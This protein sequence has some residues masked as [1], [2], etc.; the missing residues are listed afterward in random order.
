V[1]PT[2]WGSTLGE[3]EKDLH[4]SIFLFYN[5]SIGVI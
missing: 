3:G 1:A 5:K 2:W 4:Y